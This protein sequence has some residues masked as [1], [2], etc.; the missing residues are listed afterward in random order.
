V[1]LENV[2]NVDEGAAMVQAKLEA[3]GFDI[4]VVIDHA[5]GAATADVIFPPNIIVI[6]RPPR[7][8]ENRLIQKS[9]SV[10]I[11]LP[12]KF[13]IYEDEDGKVRL[14]TNSIGYLYDRHDIDPQ[15]PA[16]GTA[17]GF[18][19][20]FGK[21]DRGMITMQSNRTLSDTVTA[22]QDAIVA[23]PGIR[24][25]FVIDFGDK[26][27][28]TGNAS[29]DEFKGPVVIGFGNPDGATPL[30]IQAE[31]R[32]GID[33]PLKFLVWHGDDGEVNIATND[34]RH[35]ADRHNLEGFDEFVSIVMEDVMGFMKSGAGK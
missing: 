32:V 18:N 23:V 9:D 19:E 33:L 1:V 20:Q 26:G 13:H 6:A 3:Q 31:R 27:K 28:D 22:L 11:D 7:E 35:I 2:S 25:P 10:A 24:L 14:G 30:L 5:R 8:V 29:G 34:F 21:Q 12:M 17:D 4:T 15:F 16:A